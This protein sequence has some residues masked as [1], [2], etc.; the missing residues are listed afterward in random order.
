MA[1]AENVVKLSLHSYGRRYTCAAELIDDLASR[2]VRLPD[3]NY[4]EI[5]RQVGCT[6]QT[7]RNLAKGKTR[8]PR[9]DTLF[10]VI[11]FLHLKI[12]L[13]PAND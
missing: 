12:A 8:W 10:G 11:A 13:V 5:G 1:K 3:R 9:A 7:I 6:G 4:E 2:L